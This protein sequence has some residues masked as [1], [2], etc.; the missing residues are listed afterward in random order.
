VSDSG[1]PTEEQ[2]TMDGD[3]KNPRYTRRRA[4]AFVLA[5]A[6][7]LGSCAT[8][9]HR[10]TTRTGASAEEARP[11]PVTLTLENGGE[12]DGERRA[13]LTSSLTPSLTFVG[14]AVTE[15][16]GRITIYLT[17]MRIFT[18]WANG[19]TEGRYEASGNLE[20]RP[21]PSAAGGAAS[22]DGEAAAGVTAY[23]LY[24]TDQP[25]LWSVVEG[26][27]RYYD[28]YYRGDDGIAKVRARV[29]RLRELSRILREEFDLAPV[30][31]RMRRGSG[32]RQPFQSAVYPLLFPELA[33]GDLAP[34]VAAE[35]NGSRDELLEGPTEI[36]S[37]IAWSVRYTETVFPE[38]LHALRNSGTI[39]R[40]YEEA[41]ELF[42][43]F[44]NLNYLTA[45]LSGTVVTME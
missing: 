33:D 29:D 11:L 15:E 17:E 7:I 4:A 40:D 2:I 26:E 21:A 38:N 31:R 14:D 34:A 39:F 13:L 32:E 9:D 18:N 8:T 23:T 22:K 36:G 42:Y 35:V 20:L 24:V 6:L 44:Y 28:T 3:T 41:F 19:W 10:Y 43:S 5:A 30:Y 16:T 37:D 12:D 1:F 45:E 25:A 27:V